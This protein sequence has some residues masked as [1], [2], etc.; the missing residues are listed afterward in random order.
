MGW[1]PRGW[2][3]ARVALPG[4]VTNDGEDEGAI[5]LARQST[6]TEAAAIRKWLSA[7]LKKDMTMPSDGEYYYGSSHAKKSNWSLP[8]IRDAPQQSRHSSA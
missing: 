4:R 7:S 1:T 5:L 3:T 6:P 8:P 2:N